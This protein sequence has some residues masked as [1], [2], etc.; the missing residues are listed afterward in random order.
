MCIHVSFVMPHKQSFQ[1][2]NTFHTGTKPDI[3]HGILVK[4]VKSVFS[5]VPGNNL[6]F[7]FFFFFFQRYNT[8]NSSIFTQYT[9]TN[10][11]QLQTLL[12]SRH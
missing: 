3:K 4:K 10:G 2:Y 5:G 6:D 7:F 9:V 11:I 1:Q 8:K 12:L